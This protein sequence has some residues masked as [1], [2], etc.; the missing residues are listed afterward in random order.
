MALLAAPVILAAFVVWPLA[1]ADEG[2][3]GPL[4]AGAVLVAG[5]A[6]TLAVRTNDPWTPRHPKVS[7]VVY[8]IDQDTGRAWRYG[9]ANDRSAWAD[10]VLTADGG[11]I[12]PHEHWSWRRPMVA[13]PARAISEPAPTIALHRTREGV[14]LT[15]ALPPGARTL[16]LQLR[17]SRDARLRA[18]AGVPTDMALPAG[19]WVRVYWQ[20][21]GSGLNLAIRPGGSGKLDVRYVEA[22][23]RWPA[24]AAPLPPRPAD[25][26]AWDNSDSTL[27]TG[28]RTFTW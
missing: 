22:F 12:A 23:D 8:Q 18:V 19:K 11:K 2:A 4:L 26:M 15:A 17:S 5:V 7:Y 14:T 13:A 1:H 6:V 20:A 16:A 10:R 27:V 9:L 28:V 21:P 24:A 3:P 25:L